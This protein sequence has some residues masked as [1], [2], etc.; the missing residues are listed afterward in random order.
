MGLFAEH[1]LLVAGY[2]LR[3]LVGL[4]ELQVE[5]QSLDRVH[6]CQ[7]GAHGLRH[8]AEQV[9]MSIVYSLVVLR[10]DG[11]YLHLGAAAIVCLGFVSL[12]YLGPEHTASA[13]LGNLHKVVGG[14]VHVELDA[15]GHCACLQTSVCEGREVLSAP[16]Q[17][18]T[19]FLSD[20]SAGVAEHI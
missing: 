17:C 15:L 12:Y 3:E 11:V 8:G 14:D 20:V 1:N 4:L 16:C 5:R 19:E 7:C 6:T 18:V 2:T 13:E 10:S 9:H